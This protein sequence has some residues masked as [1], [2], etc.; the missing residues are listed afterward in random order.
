MMSEREQQQ[1]QKRVLDLETTVSR[2]QSMFRAMSAE[3]VA[4]DREIAGLKA[5]N[6]GLRAA[7]ESLRRENAEL[8]SELE[9]ARALATNA[10]TVPSGQIPPYQKSPKSNS[11]N[12]TRPGARKGHEGSRRNEPAKIDRVEEHMLCS[13][14]HCSGPVT[15]LRTDDQMRV[16]RRRIIEDI[17][18]STPEVVAHEIHQYWCTNCKAKV[19][20]CVTEALPGSRLGIRVV[21]TTAIQHFLMGFSISKITDML[22][23]EHG[24]HLTNG[25]IVDAW[26]RLAEIL[27]G[28]YDHLG[29]MVQEAGF[30][31]ADETGWRVNGKTHWLWCFCNKLIAYYVIDRSRGAQ[32]A[33]DVLGDFFKGTLIADFYAAYKLIHSRQIQRCLAHLLR[34]FKKIRAKNPHHLSEEFLSFERRIKRLVKDAIDFA[35][36]DDLD[37]PKRKEARDRFQARLQGIIAEKTSSPHVQ[38]LAERLSRHKDSIFVFVTDPDIEPTNNWAEL[39]VRFAVMMRKT[40]FGNQS[41]RGARTQEVLMSLLRTAKLRGED[42]IESTIA[43]VKQR[44]DDQHRAKFAARASDG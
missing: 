28:D 19:E 1:L 38:R 36:R 24:M 14:P 33:L 18:P 7:N 5:E 11:K 9:R 4:K 12:A 10:P 13:C 16:T 35:A 44:I 32:V 29:D 8:R 27:A 20:P 17:V 39:N 40:S 2:L 26:H 22:E 42:V 31:H 37:P 3:L 6:A 43:L 23:S 25:G 34:E 41:E 21:I 15:E 30:I